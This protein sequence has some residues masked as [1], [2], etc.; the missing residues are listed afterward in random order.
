MRHR[1]TSHGF[2]LNIHH[3]ALEG[4]KNIVACG[5]PDVQLTCIDEQLEQHGQKLKLSDIQVADLVADQFASTL[6]RKV[7]LADTLLQYECSTAND[8]TKFISKVIID[9]E[10]FG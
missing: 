7:Q 8:G 9:H 4:F 5:L 10:Q 2:A 3:T 1:I 6:E